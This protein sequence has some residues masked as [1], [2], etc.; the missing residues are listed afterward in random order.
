MLKNLFSKFATSEKEPQPSSEVINGRICYSFACGVE[1][2]QEEL[3]LG[4]DEELVGVLMELDIEGVDL[5]KTQI[6]EIIEKLL[7]DNLLHK[8]LQ[9][10]LVIPGMEQKIP[11][12]KIKQF[13]NSELQA[14]IGDFF[15]LN[16]TARDW[17]KT[18]G[19]GLISGQTTTGTSNS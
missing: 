1:A 3:T 16:P 14:V 7:S 11:V 19:S 6:K 18:I 4:Q 10:I 9:V 2:Y 13:R 5:E 12:E 17:L 8:L 15:S